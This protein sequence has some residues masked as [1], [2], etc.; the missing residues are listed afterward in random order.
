[1]STLINNAIISAV[2]SGEITGSPETRRYNVTDRLTPINVKA[3]DISIHAVHL[4]VIF[5]RYSDIKAALNW[6]AIDIPSINI[7][8]ELFSGFIYIFFYQC[9]SIGENQQF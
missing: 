6:R 5:T 9:W 3:I 2:M 7:A 4:P 1:M 8:I